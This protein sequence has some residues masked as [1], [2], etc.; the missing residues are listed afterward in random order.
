MLDPILEIEKLCVAYGEHE[1]LQDVSI[2]IQRGQFACLIGPNGAGKSTLL[3][4]IVGLVRASGGSVVSRARQI[5][6]V[7]QQLPLDAGLPLTVAEFLSLK[8]TRSR[9]WFGVRHSLREPIR[10]QLAEIG[11]AHLID[12]RLGMLSGGEFQRILVAYALINDPDFL[13]LDEPLT[14]VDIRG[15]L[16]FDGLLHHLHDHRHITILMV[17]H[18][19][20]LVEHLSDVVFCINRDLCCLGHPDEVLKPENLAKAYGHL[21]GMVRDAGGSAFIPMANIH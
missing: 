10:A 20:H 21:P 18:D 9:W 2:T 1:V 3:K 6:Y 11:A 13:L 8:L 5:G 15:G 12:R 16:S 4:T 7:P 19:L 17:S 14:G